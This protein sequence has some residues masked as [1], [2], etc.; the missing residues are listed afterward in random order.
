MR[1]AR[2]AREILALILVWIGF[3]AEVQAAAEPAQVSREDVL[4]NLGVDEVAADY[5]VLIDTSQ[6]MADSG[7]YGQVQRALRPFLES[8][9]P[10]DH[11]A[12]FTFATNPE[13]RYNAVVGEP[14]TD[15]LV[16]LPPA[17]GADTDIGRAIERGLDHLERPDALDVGALVLVTDGMHD[18]GPGSVYATNDGPAWH[19]LAKRAEE[20]AKRQHRINAYALALASSTDAGLLHQVFPNTVVLSLPEG[21]LGVRLQRIK[22]ES[23]IEKGRRI[24]A[25]D[26]EEGT[27]EVDWGE[28]RNLDLHSGVDELALTLRSTMAHVPLEL[29]NLSVISQGELRVQT[30]SLPPSVSLKPHQSVTIPVRLQFGPRFMAETGEA[31]L[32]PCEGLVF[33]RRQT[34]QRGEL[35]LDATIGSPWATTLRDD[36]RFPDFSPVVSGATTTLQASCTNGLSLWWL[37]LLALLAWASWYVFVGRRPKLR[38]QLLASVPG[39]ALQQSLMLRGRK[40]RIGTQRGSRLVIPG[41]GTVRHQRVSRLRKRRSRD[42]WLRITYATDGGKPTTRTCRPNGSVAFDH[43]TFTYQ[44]LTTS[45]PKSGSRR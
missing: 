40:M 42:P 21:Q 43:T 5:V 25:P 22:Q 39:H 13:E 41:R 35:R 23:R 12:V 36:L 14:P 9:A 2:G 10:E 31:A 33:G 6:S 1:L 4:K 29:T 7:L 8:L 32:D 45:P 38:G 34:T 28:A 30:V 19:A 24:V 37:P 3:L 26:V 18:P 16:N 27:V 11:V 44:P 20:L 17:D 15:P